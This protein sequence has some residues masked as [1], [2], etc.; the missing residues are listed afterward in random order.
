MCG[1]FGIIRTDFMTQM[2]KEAFTKM[3]YLSSTRGIDS[4]GYSPS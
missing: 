4:T 2:D 3:S 1:V